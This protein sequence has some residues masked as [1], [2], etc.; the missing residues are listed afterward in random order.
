[1]QL[2]GVQ[3]PF[4][5]V[6][7]GA[8]KIVKQIDGLAKKA[9]R[10]ERLKIGGK[11]IDFDTSGFEKSI[12][13]V[14]KRITKTVA[15]FDRLKAPRSMR[16]TDKGRGLDAV[17]GAAADDAVRK[18]TDIKAA[19]SEVQ[20]AMSAIKAA[21]AKRVF[22]AQEAAQFQKEIKAVSSEIYRMGM[23]AEEQFKNVVKAMK[24]V[25]AEQASRNMMDPSI[26]MSGEDAQFEEILG[27][28]REVGKKGASAISSEF[29]IAMREVKARMQALADQ[30]ISFRHVGEAIV[31]DINKAFS[32][33]NREFRGVMASMSNTVS[34]LDLSEKLA[35]E[36][37]SPEVANSVATLQEKLNRLGIRE[38]SLATINEQ[39]A[40]PGI[41]GNARDDLH[42]KLKAE[43]AG[44][45]QEMRK[46]AEANNNLS[47]AFFQKQKALLES[48]KAGANAL[49]QDYKG[50][51][52]AI[53]RIAEQ[54]T[55]FK[56]A[57]GDSLT[58]MELGND[59]LGNQQKL[60]QS[61]VSI[62]RQGGEA[63]ASLVAES[64]NAVGAFR[65][66]ME[67]ADRLGSAEKEVAATRKDSNAT[68]KMSI[69]L[70]REQ[71]NALKQASLIGV[72]GEALVA[73][74]KMMKVEKE[75]GSNTATMKL[76]ETISGIA[77][78]INS[79]AVPSMSRLNKSVAQFEAVSGKSFS[80]QRTETKMLEQALDGLVAN[81]KNVEKAATKS[82]VAEQRA[83]LDAI[84]QLTQKVAATSYGAENSTKLNDQMK[85]VDAARD[86]L[87]V[88]ERRVKFEDELLAKFTKVQAMQVAGVSV[89]KNYEKMQELYVQA[90]KEESSLED[91]IAAQVRNKANVVRKLAHEVKGMQQIAGDMD[92]LPNMQIAQLKGALETLEMIRT[93]VGQMESRGS[94]M[95]VIGGE[96]YNLKAVE[97]QISAVQE[98]LYTRQ[99]VAE[100]AERGRRV[101]EAINGVLREREALNNKI[102]DTLK[103]A[104]ASV[105]MQAAGYDT[106]LKAVDAAISAVQK[107]AGIT[108]NQLDLDKLRAT[109]VKELYTEYSRLADGN[110]EFK[111]PLEANKSLMRQRD[112][113]KKISDIIDRDHT[114]QLETGKGEIGLTNIR[115]HLASVESKLKAVETVWRDSSKSF[116]KFDSE[117][118]LKLEQ[119]VE[120][121]KEGMSGLASTIKMSG[122]AGEKSFASMMNGILKAENPLK[123]YQSALSALHKEQMSNAAATDKQRISTLSELAAVQRQA[124]AVSGLKKALQGVDDKMRAS[125][126]S[127]SQALDNPQATMENMAADPKK[128]AA[129]EQAFQKLSTVTTEM[130]AAQTSK[131]SVFGALTS[132]VVKFSGALDAVHEKIRGV[133]N[134]VHKID[135]TKVRITP[136]EAS[137]ARAAEEQKLLVTIKEQYRALQSGVD[138]LQNWDAIRKNV[139]DAARR[140]LNL[141][142]ENIAVLTSQDK[143]YDKMIEHAKQLYSNAANDSTAPI[144]ARSAALLESERI[145]LRVREAMKGMNFDTKNVGFEK[146]L[147]DVKE[148][149]S[150]LGYVPESLRKAYREADVFH[151]ALE[152]SVKSI[153]EMNA[154]GGQ[155]YDKLGTDISRIVGS[156]DDWEKAQKKIYRNADFITESSDKEITNKRNQIREAERLAGI[157]RKIVKL[158]DDITNKSATVGV[159]AS[160]LGTSGG[161]AQL[162]DATKGEQNA[163]MYVDIVKSNKEMMGL[164]TSMQQAL[165]KSKEM[166]KVF[167]GYDDHLAKAKQEVDKVDKALSAYAEKKQ[168]Q[169]SRSAGSNM[170]DVFR[171]SWFIQLRAFWGMYMGITEMM[172]AVM[173][174]THTLNVMQAVTQSSANSMNEMEESFQNLSRTVPIAMT[175]TAEAALQVA[176]AGM[177]AEETIQIIN[178]A[179]A[180]AHTTKSDLTTV[181]DVITVAIR[182][183][184]MAATQSDQIADL[185]FNAISKSRASMEGLQQA[186][187]YLSGIAPQANVSLQDTLG[188][189]G[190]L[191][192]AG[193]SMSKAATYSRQVLND[194]MNPSAKL[195][196]ILGS[197]GIKLSEVDPRFNSLAS[198]FKKLHD[199]GMD[200]SQAFEGMSVRGANAFSIALSNADM[201]K[202]FTGNLED[203]GALMRE[204]GHT[205]D[206]LSSKLQLL[207]NSFI[208]AANSLKDFI[209]PFLMGMADGLA[210]FANGLTDVI[211]AIAG[212]SDGGAGNKFEALGEVIGKA[213]VPLAV[214]LTMLRFSVFSKIAGGI[215]ALSGAFKGV[216]T[217]I[218]G[219]SSAAGVLRAILLAISAHPIIAII[220][221]LAA[222]G[223]AIYTFAS[224]GANDVNKLTESVDNLREAMKKVSAI[225]VNV[226][227][228]ES[229]GA[230]VATLNQKY[231]YGEGSL[232]SEGGR[233]NARSYFQSV[234]SKMM[235]DGSEEV[236]KLGRE[237]MDGMFDPKGSAADAE[238]WIKD[239]LARMRAAL[240][241]GHSQQIEALS[242][243]MEYGIKSV[244]IAAE[245][246]VGVIDEMIG[247]L[248]EAQETV[249]GKDDF[250]QSFASMKLK[251]F[252]GD[253]VND[254]SKEAGEVMAAINDAV[255]TTPVTAESV[256]ALT[257]FL[258]QAYAVHEELKKIKAQG[259]AENVQF[260]KD[261]NLILVE[262]LRLLERVEE[263]RKRAIK[264]GTFEE[265]VAEST[266][267]ANAPSEVA[268]KMQDSANTQA[269]KKR[270][271]SAEAAA[272]GLKYA[273]QLAFVAPT[274]QNIQAVKDR[275]GQTADDIRVIME[276][277]AAAGK[278]LFTIDATAAKAIMDS[279][280]NSWAAQLEML[281]LTDKDGKLMFDEL[282]GSARK[283]AASMQFE[284]A[285]ISFQS[286]VKKWGVGKEVLKTMKAEAKNVPL[287]S[288]E[289][290]QGKIALVADT[291]AKM[292]MSPKMFDPKDIASVGQIVE[293]LTKKQ[294]A[295]IKAVI[296]SRSELRKNI[297]TNTTMKQALHEVLRAYDGYDSVDDMMRA[298]VNMAQ[299]LDDN[300]V[301][302][303]QSLAANKNALIDIAE[304]AEV[305]NAELARLGEITGQN[306]AKAMDTEK[307]YNSL[308][309]SAQSKF[310]SMGSQIEASIRKVSTLTESIRTLNKEMMQDQFDYQE[311]RLDVI[312]STKGPNTQFQYEQ[313]KMQR[314]QAFVQA[315]VQSPS[316][317][318]GPELEE[319]IKG[320][321]DN[322]LAFAAKY[323]YQGAGK[324][325][326]DKSGKMNNLLVKMQLQRQKVQELDL[327]LQQANL[328]MQRAAYAQMNVTLTNI[329]NVL[330][331]LNDSIKV[332]SGEKP[333][334]KGKDG[335]SPIGK[336]TVIDAKAMAEAATR[337]AEAESKLDALNKQLK[338]AREAAGDTTAAALE[339]AD[340]MAIQEQQTLSAR[341]AMDGWVSS[342]GS[343]KDIVNSTFSGMMDTIKDGLGS[344][345]KGGLRAAIQGDE[346]DYDAIFT[347]M[348]WNLMDSYV[349][350]VMNLA[351]Q[352]MFGDGGFMNALW[353][354]ETAPGVSKTGVETMSE[355]ASTAMENAAGATGPET[356]FATAV[357]Q[358]MAAVQQMQASTIQ[359]QQTALQQTAMQQQGAVQETMAQTRQA[360]HDATQNAQEQRIATQND[361]AATKQNTAADKNMASAGNKGGGAGGA[362][363]PA[364]GSSGGGFWSGVLGF[365]GMGFSGGGQ[366]NDGNREKDSTTAALT[367]GEFVIQE[368]IVRKYGVEFFNSLNQGKATQAFNSIPSVSNDDVKTNAAS[369]G[370]KPPRTENRQPAGQQ[371]G[372]KDNRPLKINN[373]VDPKVVEKYVGSDRGKR[374]IMNIVS[375]HPYFQSKS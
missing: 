138:V 95:A 258:K 96:E 22:P 14:E 247:K 157:M 99:K 64:L 155:V 223:L 240:S 160:K 171:M 290:L 206:D 311:R 195:T 174:Y 130:T 369:S 281:R 11:G 73:F 305:M 318:R 104:H 71:S 205:T 164:I 128:L 362:P 84:Q 5:L 125:G 87:A 256:P 275:M 271:E 70:L 198:I 306:T 48:L 124:A 161:A 207:M 88:V 343:A 123:S 288:F 133:A 270:I 89:A 255:K 241:E 77:S 226:A 242:K 375:Q 53:M 351:S 273:V 54:T 265:R 234:L 204:Y 260:G 303:R 232:E 344:A 78:E 60:N 274:K 97:K 320:I 314:E 297:S 259:D 228:S 10:L 68:L 257:T 33:I 253:P 367:K 47:N 237:L 249:A 202:E 185:M 106:Y 103:E 282:M 340:S 330:Q 148:L 149:K 339:L 69:A 346:V 43:L 245:S 307:A 354:G 262:S 132:E 175:K 57:M 34:Q 24:R 358:F 291:W 349:D 114:F 159:D 227:R 51:A 215:A 152:K 199:A 156:L 222:A 233:E 109:A 203:S 348:Y 82:S 38:E 94:K 294:F 101:D 27:K 213:I 182:S 93:L 141:G 145:M 261:F 172:Q 146:M 25:G 196:A 310:A 17:F 244:G 63:E 166:E 321:R 235:Q 21:G 371:G 154:E 194:L 86:E 220:T 284:K 72:D 46:V 108:E 52:D 361:L 9:E 359:Q 248:R 126:L 365:L 289:D 269:I 42:K 162:A 296:K 278:S 140:G 353:N 251:W 76:R 90:K 239:A 316:G 142:K 200:V 134:D 147:A 41:S 254:A 91:V 211:D 323:Q 117:P 135:L 92:L 324:D 304:E 136:D 79:G 283:L 331:V 264:A 113:L 236:K 83:A 266:K 29:A 58:K 325:A 61:I 276:R 186:M 187:G 85:M 35:A 308:A 150:T 287:Q 373:M 62:I 295:Y 16:G 214:L 250:F 67:Y 39:L 231:G 342:L 28:M 173:E 183:W 302:M 118:L 112:L 158:S 74:D 336:Q 13:S 356:I 225:K 105:E 229:M 144:E 55:R 7:E 18:A 50:N 1:M 184:G 366:V 102:V 370:V 279:L 317:L 178:A 285:G 65:K 263:Q 44:I 170:F 337:T 312:Q 197:L 217:A 332:A 116:M 107:Q 347:E 81:Y 268:E 169:A 137:T 216:T 313:E 12:E 26:K 2:E 4:E 188:L 45:D 193:L 66:T 129:M 80:E 181:A 15:L 328:A 301:K 238:K 31:S 364:A 360:T 329:F 151:T 293:K 277:I 98:E 56:Q 335:K 209:G 75:L 309:K 36:I 168:R 8:D 111:G 131:T 37:M 355:T 19:L 127:L 327:K 219:A 357:Q 121:T 167:A 246:S 119:K 322:L 115:D 334:P 177:N 122:E 180:L 345:I 224:D 368:P 192:N 363:T 374:A 20:D 243:E 30:P 272:G 208:G 230:G 110:F 23:R 3:A 372:G 299:M 338:D 341:E 191:T 201:L 221:A 189:V 280:N 40:D 267:K 298:P 300:F 139:N 218:M 315:Q 120:S 165:G 143:I 153:E 286:L 212:L 176:K 100:E 59:V 32:T 179:A 49:G 252:G 6:L 292:K 190:V 319:A 210:D 352:E 350:M 333:A 163:K 326:M